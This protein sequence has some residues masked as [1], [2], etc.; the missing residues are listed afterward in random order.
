[1]SSYQKE[2]EKYRD[3][4]EDEILKTLSPEELE[5]LDC[6]LQEMDPE[7]ML[8]PAGLRQRDQTKKSPTGPLDREALLQYLEQQALEVKERDD[9]VPFTGEKKGKPYIQ[10]KREIPAEEQITLEPELEEALANAT[11]AEMCDIAA[12][13]GMY[14]LMSNKQYYDAICSGEIC[15]T[16]GISSECAGGAP[17]GSRQAA[18][19]RSRSRVTSDER[20]EGRRSGT[21]WGSFLPPPIRCGSA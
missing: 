20:A 3:I 21:R 9:L 11:D 15:N 14:T 1:M 6:E 10:P 2:L 7:N 12:I 16:E 19:E 18:P 13:L 4:D 5:Q 17:Q 8:L